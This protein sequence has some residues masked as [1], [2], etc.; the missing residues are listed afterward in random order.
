VCLNKRIS[1]PKPLSDETNHTLTRRIAC[2][3][4]GGLGQYLLRGLKLAATA[5]TAP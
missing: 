2:T 1:S 3:V 4:G 5:T